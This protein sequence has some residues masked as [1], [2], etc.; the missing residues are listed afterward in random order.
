[1]SSTPVFVQTPKIVSLALTNA[2]TEQALFTAAAAEKVVAVIV[3]SSEAGA[4]IVKLSYTRGGTAYFMT[5]ASVAAGS[6]INGT[7]ATTD[8]LAS[9][10]IPGLPID[11]DGQRYFFLQS[12]D[13]LNATAVTAH[14]SSTIHVTVIYADF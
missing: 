12:G 11:N 10:L 14:S 9:T 2:T 5:A 13:V 6:G 8:L 7:A 3:T 4:I 1:M